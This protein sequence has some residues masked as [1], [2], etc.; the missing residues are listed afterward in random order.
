M[1]SILADAFATFLVQVFEPQSV[2]FWFPTRLL[3]GM[4]S[5]ISGGSVGGHVHMSECLAALTAGNRSPPERDGRFYRCKGCNTTSA[6]LS[7]SGS[8]SP[9]RQLVGRELTYAPLAFAVGEVECEVV[10]RLKVFGIIHQ[11]AVQLCQLSL[12]LG[13][14]IAMKPLPPFDPT[15]PRERSNAR[16]LQLVCNRQQNHVFRVHV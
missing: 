13:D 6:V 1:P 3:R 10:D 8:S 15:F 5:D 11:L 7:S 9:E 4:I 12:H 16:R 2:I 14:G